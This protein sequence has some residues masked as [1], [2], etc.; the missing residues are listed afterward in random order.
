MRKR[1]YFKK[2]DDDG[3]E[4]L[5][6]RFYIEKG[7]IADF[8]VQYE[9]LVNN[10]WRIIVRYDTAHGFFHR[11]ELAPD[12]EKKKKEIQIYDYNSAMLYAEQDLTDRWYWYKER[13]LKKMK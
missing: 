8:V 4:R 7:K 12:G 6:F 2:L 5:R 3:Y 9:S 10:R 11:D 13:Y 1:E